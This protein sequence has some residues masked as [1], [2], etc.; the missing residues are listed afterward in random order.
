MIIKYIW[1]EVNKEAV[2]ELL[3][4]T[5]ARKTGAIK[6]KNAVSK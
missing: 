6:I 2:K 1:C 4:R 5:F 3:A